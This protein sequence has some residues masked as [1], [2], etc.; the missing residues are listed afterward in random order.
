M[1]VIHEFK[2]TLVFW[3]GCLAVFLACDTS[4]DNDLYFRMSEK[5][6]LFYRYS[7]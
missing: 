5:T 4:G 1:D 3:V 6:F 7:Q 2:L